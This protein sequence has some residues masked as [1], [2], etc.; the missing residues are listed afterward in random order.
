MLVVVPISQAR[1]SLEYHPYPAQEACYTLAPRAVL[2]VGCDNQRLA[3]HLSGAQP[4]VFRPQGWL[5]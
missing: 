2:V 1:I 5:E 3:Q 4:K